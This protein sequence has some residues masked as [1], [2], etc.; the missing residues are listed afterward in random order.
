MSKRNASSNRTLAI[1]LII[2]VIALLAPLLDGMV[3]A[4]VAALLLI[5]WR[6]WARRDGSDLWAGITTIGLVVLAIGLPLVLHGSDATTRNALGVLGLAIAAATFASTEWLRRTLR[7]FAVLTIVSLGV[8]TFRVGASQT[9]SDTCQQLT[10]LRRTLAVAQTRNALNEKLA[11]AKKAADVRKAQGTAKAALPI[12]QKAIVEGGNN[13]PTPRAK[14]RLIHAAQDLLNALRQQTGPKITDPD[15]EEAYGKLVTFNRRFAPAPE[16]VADRK[17]WR[18][19]NA[20]IAAQEALTDANASVPTEGVDDSDVSATLPSAASGCPSAATHIDLLTWR[21]DVYSFRAA[22]AKNV[23]GAEKEQSKAA[24]D[25]EAA[26]TAKAKAESARDDLLAKLDEGQTDPDDDWMETLQAG[27]QA[28]GAEALSWLPGSPVPNRWFWILIFVAALTW[29]WILERR[30]NAR[31]AGPV[32]YT[33]KPAG[34][35]P[36]DVGA[37]DPDDAQHGR[38]DD[39]PDK[40][41]KPSVVASK[42]VQE[43]LFAAA[44]TKNLPEPGT[45]PGS[46]TTTPLTDIQGLATAA[47]PSKVVEAVLK[48]VN[49]VLNAARG[50][51]VKAQVLPPLPD[52]PQ[53][54]VWTRISDASNNR[55]TASNDVAAETAVEACRAAG[56]WAAATVLANSPRVPRWARWSPQIAEAMAAY[57]SADKP[58]LDDLKQAVLMAPASGL[59][60]QKLGDELSLSHASMAATEAYARAVTVDPSYN[61][62]VY[63]LAASLAALS[64]DRQA[65]TEAPYSDQVSL[66]D[67][68]DRAASRLNVTFHHD[69]LGG[70]GRSELR[71]LSMTL[72]DVLAAG[73]RIDN[74]FMQYSRRDQRDGMGPLSRVIGPFGARRQAL[75]MIRAARLTVEAAPLEAGGAAGA[76]SEGE[77][78]DEISPELGDSEGTSPVAGDSEDTSQEYNEV[79]EFAEDTRSGWH[80]CYNLACY[81]AIKRQPDKAI[82]WLKTALTRPGVEAMARTWADKDPDLESLQGLPRYEQLPLPKSPDTEES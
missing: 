58:K 39:R 36:S 38:A 49:A 7:I 32:T 47:D 52:A 5:V 81:H 24:K 22:V 15:M 60:L 67:W 72:F 42:E 45:T 71:S 56:Y 50:S 75:F 21:S 16:V 65:W 10:D 51:S 18:A 73:L 23:V 48:A 40:K 8:I 63:R 35:A 13:R 3:L 37:E 46:P 54:R 4:L 61:N 30:S 77:G 26:D 31:V 14:P 57:E 20:A 11:I 28:M 68:L 55:A 2:V 69:A 27:A 80:V 74:Y 6:V 12:L 17:I 9:A 64:R 66:I 78:V 44:L 43:A 33:F 34:D 41:V 59:P 25:K 53:W 70:A 82:Y 1:L 19:A 29:W 76:P 62:A 79:S